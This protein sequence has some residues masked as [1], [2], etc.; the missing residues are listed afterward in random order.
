[1]P[2]RERPFDRGTRRGREFVLQIGREVRS[3][4]IDRGLTLAEVGAALGISA[5]ECSR[6]ERGLS[7]S[8]RL[9]TLCQYGA[10][11]GL[12]LSVRAFAG[13]EPIRDAGQA[14]LAAR[15]QGLLHRTLAWRSEVPLP[16]P[17]DPRAWDGV[18]TGSD[19][20]YGVEFESAPHDGQALARGLELKQRDGMVDG[21]ILVLPR[22]RRTREFLAAATPVLKPN[23]PV[24]GLRAVELLRAGI[25][26]AGNAIVVI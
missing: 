15:F 13:G 8:V 19:W 6:I 22:T 25:C 24:P 4:R 10:I 12:D 2:A 5:A 1:M 14:P 23:F 17:G 16:R 11:V 26:P 7:P 20:R 18:I 3:A 9:I 21:V